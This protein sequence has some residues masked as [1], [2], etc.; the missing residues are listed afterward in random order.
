MKWYRHKVQTFVSRSCREK[1]TTNFLPALYF[2]EPWCRHR[3]RGSTGT[4]RPMFLYSRP[5]LRETSRVDIREKMETFNN[6]KTVCFEN[7][8]EVCDFL[9][10]HIACCQSGCQKNT[11]KKTMTVQICV[12]P[13]SAAPHFV[14]E[15]TAQMWTNNWKR[16]TIK[17]NCDLGS[18]F[19]E[20]EPWHQKCNTSFALLKF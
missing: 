1:P 3:A 11:N 16:A 5:Q 6:S 17:T 18:N 19:Y 9:L 14:V 12:L 4:E 7:K 15:T 2:I 13:K 10:C 20:I 8:Q